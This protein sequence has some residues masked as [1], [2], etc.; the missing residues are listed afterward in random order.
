MKIQ[1]GDAIGV[2]EG[3]AADAGAG[4]GH[5]LKFSHRRHRSGASHLHRHLEQ[6]AGSFLGWEFQRN[7]PAGC[8]LGEP[9]SLLQSQVV[10]L[11]HHAVGGIGEVMATLFPVVAE[12]VDGGQV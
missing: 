11:H 9:G 5:G 7:G 6:P 4:Q 1:F 10:Q 3:G 8:L 12:A 2:V